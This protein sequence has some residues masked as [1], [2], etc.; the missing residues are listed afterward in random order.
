MYYLCTPT[1]IIMQHVEGTED[2]KSRNA[3]SKAEQENPT[4]IKT[5]TWITWEGLRNPQTFQINFRKT[6]LS[7]SLHF[8][9]ITCSYTSVFKKKQQSGCG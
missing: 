3:Q 7:L 4:K 5:P 1:L 2:Q 8:S 9:L 6:P